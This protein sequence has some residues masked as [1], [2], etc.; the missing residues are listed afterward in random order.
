MAT[1]SFYMATN[2][3]QEL[4]ISTFSIISLWK[5]YVAIVTIVLIRLEQKTIVRPHINGNVCL[6]FMEKLWKKYE[7]NNTGEESS[8][9]EG[10]VL[11]WFGV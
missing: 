10:L 4:S 1:P 2:L 3:K 9:Y 6:I 5:P 11:V 7:A 8:I